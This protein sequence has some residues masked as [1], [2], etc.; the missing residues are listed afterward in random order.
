[1]AS[2][3]L[4]KHVLVSRLPLLSHCLVTKQTF[5]IVLLRL[6]SFKLRRFLST[7]D[8]S[9]EDN[10]CQ[11]QGIGKLIK[12]KPWKGIFK[13]DWL[14]NVAAN[15][16]ISSSLLLT[17]VN[18]QQTFFKIVPFQVLF[19]SPEII[20]ESWGCGLYMSAAYTRVFTVVLMTVYSQEKPFG[21]RNYAL[22]DHMVL[23]K[24]A[25]LI[26]G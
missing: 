11:S 1:M 4:D 23:T 26:L 5:C 18:K 6:F 25:S 12:E 8:F 15:T 9:S 7:V 20:L 14:I 21:V 3:G 13:V 19:F 17:S 22:S 2:I 16:Q 24:D 10:C